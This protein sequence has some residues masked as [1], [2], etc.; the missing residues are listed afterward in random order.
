L[1]I[2]DTSPKT[3]A[4]ALNLLRTDVV[5]YERLRQN[6]IKAR[7]VLNWQQEEKKLIAFYKQTLG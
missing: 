1:L 6:C 3:I 4:N 5:L 7:E 2:P